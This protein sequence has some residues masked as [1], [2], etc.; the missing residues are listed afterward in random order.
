MLKIMNFFDRIINVKAEREVI[1]IENIIMFVLAV[2]V[3]RI[4]L[5]SGR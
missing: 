2:T 4:V 1:I 5:D 3:L